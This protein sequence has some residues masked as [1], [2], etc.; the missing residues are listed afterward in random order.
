MDLDGELSFS[1]ALASACVAESGRDSGCGLFVG[2]CGGWISSL[3]FVFPGAGP[4]GR[5]RIIVARVSP[6][7]DIKRSA[8][9][10]F[11]ALTC[12]PTMWRVFSRRRVIEAMPRIRTLQ[13]LQAPRC[14]ST[15]C[16]YLTGGKSSPKYRSE[17]M[18]P[19]S[20]FGPVCHARNIQNRFLHGQQ[21]YSD[22]YGSVTGSEASPDN[23]KSHS[24]RTLCASFDK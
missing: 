18:R 13:A 12:L 4:Y 15:I 20:T 5:K 19:K 17:R 1:T 9:F 8:V 16:R 23:Y 22:E 24:T 2:V 6:T 7:R 11:Y 10:S 21:S 14:P 3:S